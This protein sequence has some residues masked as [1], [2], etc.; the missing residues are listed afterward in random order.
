MIHSFFGVS[1]NKNNPKVQ[2]TA[3]DRMM[4]AVTAKARYMPMPMMPPSTPP[5]KP[6]VPRAYSDFTAAISSPLTAIEMSWINAPR[7]SV[8]TKAKMLFMTCAPSATQLRQL[9]AK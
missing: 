9:I 7:N 4:P 8:T 3:A 5:P 2:S 6:L 1:P